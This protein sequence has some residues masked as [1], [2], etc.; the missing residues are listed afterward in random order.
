M[1]TFL[2]ALVLFTL[3]A[4]DPS[5]SCR[6]THRDPGVPATMILYCSQILPSGVEMISVGKYVPDHTIQVTGS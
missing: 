5:W 2:K 3:H 4:S 1:I 6:L